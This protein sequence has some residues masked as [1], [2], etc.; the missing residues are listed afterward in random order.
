VMALAVAKRV[1][2]GQYGGIVKAKGGSDTA[3]SQ[4]STL[5][6]PGMA[7][8]PW[9]SS[10]ASCSFNISSHEPANEAP[11]SEEKATRRA[12]QCPHGVRRTLGPEL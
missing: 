12:Q 4:T 9:G 11:E 6:R 10:S 5:L 8:S 2:Q 7:S 1:H 3:L